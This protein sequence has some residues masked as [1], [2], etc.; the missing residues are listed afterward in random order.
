MSNE[1]LG[2]IGWNLPMR[3]IVFE[4]L[5]KRP[6]KCSLK[7]SLLYKIK[8][9]CFWDSV[10]LT[11]ELLK[12][13]LEWTGLSN[14]NDFLSLLSQIRVKYH[15][16]LIG[17]L[18]YIS[19]VIVELFGT[20]SDASRNLKK[21]RIIRKEFALVIRPSV[22]LL[23]S[24]KKSKVPMIQP[25]GTPALTSAKLELWPSNTTL[26][27]LLFRKSITMFNSSSEIPCCCN[28]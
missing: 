26:C 15:F 4:I 22:R 19:P 7:F 6:F 18:T 13:R 21:W 2:R 1:N 24:F 8:P 16:P 10:W 27:F 17:P 14:E 9:R 20:S 3:P 5:S 28:L 23:I 12:V 25:C 11:C